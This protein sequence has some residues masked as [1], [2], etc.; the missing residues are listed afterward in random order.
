MKP[1]K[2]DFLITYETEGRYRVLFKIKFLFFFSRWIPV[3]YQEAEHTEDK[4][5]EFESFA[6]ATNFIEMITE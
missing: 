6:E 2:E 5:M 4:P 3:T 1:K